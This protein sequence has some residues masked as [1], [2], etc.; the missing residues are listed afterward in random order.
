MHNSKPLREA[1]ILSRHSDKERSEQNWM[2]FSDAAE[3]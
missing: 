3:V 2:S 1:L